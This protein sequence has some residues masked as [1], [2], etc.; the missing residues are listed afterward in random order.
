MIQASPLTVGASSFLYIVGDSCRLSFNPRSNTRPYNYD[1]F[2]ITTIGGEFENIPLAKS[3]DAYL[4]FNYN[5][6]GGCQLE[7]KSGDNLL[8]AFNSY[9]KPLLKLEGPFTTRVGVPITLTVRDARDNAAVAGAVLNGLETLTTNYNGQVTVT[10]ATSGVFPVKADKSCAI[11]SN[12]LDIR[13][14]A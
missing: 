14:T 1:D 7:V 6:V 3:W 11:R 2:H 5:Q 10:F 13:V 4:N 8:W 12:K 9:K